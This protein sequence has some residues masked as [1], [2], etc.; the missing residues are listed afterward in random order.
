LAG[1]ENSNAPSNA[2]KIRAIKIHRF[3]W[4]SMSNLFEHSMQFDP[5]RGL[6]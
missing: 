3:T 6:C 2:S 4:V 5:A 1:A